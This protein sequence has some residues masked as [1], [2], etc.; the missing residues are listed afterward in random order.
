MLAPGVLLAW[1]LASGKD[2][3]GYLKD[4]ASALWNVAPIS[5]QGVKEIAEEGNFED[6]IFSLMELTGE[7]TSV[8]NR[9]KANKEQERLKRERGVP[10]KTKKKFQ[11]A[12]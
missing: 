7:Q 11:L 3:R 2:V 9:E 1:E 5:L 4:R 8:F 12:F 6:F 10:S